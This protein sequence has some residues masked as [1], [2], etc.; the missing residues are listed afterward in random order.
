MIDISKDD[1]TSYAYCPKCKKWAT[2]ENGQTIWKPY[3][4]MTSEEQQA[5]NKGQNDFNMGAFKPKPRICPNCKNNK[6]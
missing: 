3:Y 1:T 4:Q 5:I 2:E 6:L